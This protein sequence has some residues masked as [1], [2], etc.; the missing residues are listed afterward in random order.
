MWVLCVGICLTNRGVV[1]P[2]FD[3]QLVILEQLL[4][5]NSSLSSFGSVKGWRCLICNESER[6]GPESRIRWV[7]L[8]EPRCL[9][10]GQIKFVG[11]EHG[12]EQTKFAQLNWTSMTRFCVLCSLTLCSM[13]NMERWNAT[14]KNLI[15]IAKK[16]LTWKL[17]SKA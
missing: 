14:A 13:T 6:T 1:C 4:D 11:S 8:P 3:C 9:T 17:C 16:F 10:L 15:R 12:V 2:P 7:H 5:C